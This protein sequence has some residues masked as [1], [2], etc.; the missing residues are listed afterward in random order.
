MSTASRLI[1]AALAVTISSAARAEPVDLQLILAADVSISVDDME[2][3]LQREG[4]AAA[5]TDPKILAAIRNGARH[6]IALCVIEWSG[7]SAQR[8]VVDWT[9]IR[10]ETSALSA[11]QTLRTAPRAFAGATAIG[12]A[13][14]FAMKQFERSGHE[15]LRRVID[16]SGDGDNNNGRPVEYARNDAIAASVTIN[17]LT[18]VN[19]HP[20]HGFIG[21]TQPVGGIG[22]YYRTR[23]IGGTGSFVLSID[24]FDGFAQ[25][26]TR[27][28]EVEIAGTGSTKRLTGR[29]RPDRVLP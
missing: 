15:S 14:D 12:A 13:I 20:A 25:A 26:M 7:A 3:R 4:Y 29:L 10:D 23:V 16:I 9:V 21:H 19:E 5:I 2:F 18:I 17:G 24:G 6:A 28:L 8:V 27:K 1:I 22:E 11:A